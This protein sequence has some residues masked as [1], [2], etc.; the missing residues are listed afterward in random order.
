MGFIVRKWLVDRSG[1]DG[2]IIITKEEDKILY[3]LELHEEPEMIEFMNEIILKVKQPEESL[4][5][6][7]KHPI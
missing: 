2:A 5:S 3:S 6:Q 7:V 4:K 1:Y